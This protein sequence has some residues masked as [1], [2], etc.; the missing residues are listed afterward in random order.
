MLGGLWAG[1]L[2]W[3]IPWLGFGEHVRAGP[4]WMGDPLGVV[5]PGGSN[6][7]QVMPAGALERT[8]E[9]RPTVR[10]LVL[11]PAESPGWSPTSRSTL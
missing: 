4:L 10:A 5:S 1:P 2:L 9:S 6:H 11:D 3:E 8:G 7:P